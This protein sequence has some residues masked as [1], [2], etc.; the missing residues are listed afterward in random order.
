MCWI[1][2]KTRLDRIRNGNERERER[3]ERERERERERV[4]SGGQL[5]KVWNEQGR[6]VGEE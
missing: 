3:G 5:D 6:N 1:C 2:C 4:E